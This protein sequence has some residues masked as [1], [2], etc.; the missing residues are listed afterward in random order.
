[1]GAEGDRSL[2]REK[3]GRQLLAPERGKFKRWK[4]DIYTEKGKDRNK[5][6]NLLFVLKEA[7]K[8][9]RKKK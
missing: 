5:T 9:I 3:A 6:T 4:C 2:I 1:M 8:K 7:N